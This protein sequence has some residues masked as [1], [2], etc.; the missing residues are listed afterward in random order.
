MIRIAVS[1]AAGKMGQHACRAIHAAPDLDLVACLGRDDVLE[2]VIH[3]TQPDV[4]I[5]LTNPNQLFERMQRVI[6]QHVRPVVGSSG[7]TPTQVAALQTQCAAQQLGGIIAPNFS[8]S[9]I[10]M[11]RY[12]QDAARHFDHAEII[13]LHHDQKKDA[14]SGTAKKTAEMIAAVAQPKESTEARQTE[15]HSAARGEHYCDVPIHAVRLPGLVAHQAVM[16]GAAG[17]TLTIRQD[18]TSRES[19]MPG[20]L[21][22]CRHVMTSTELLYGLE[23]LI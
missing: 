6:A 22:C 13:E 9:A 23:T 21:L 7:L 3:N 2:E 11:M 18:S 4:L 20:L 17:E 14:P 16:F 5:D 15:S 19:F 12:A 10:L 8:I 1:G